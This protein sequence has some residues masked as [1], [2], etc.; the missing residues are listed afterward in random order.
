MI[1]VRGLVG[2]QENSKNK[3]E[4]YGGPV[5]LKKKIRTEGIPPKFTIMDV[6]LYHKVYF[7]QDE[8]RCILIFFIV[9]VD[10]VINYSRK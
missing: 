8:S 7:N 1:K 5:K 10:F 4:K 3:K 6:I 9:V 2:L